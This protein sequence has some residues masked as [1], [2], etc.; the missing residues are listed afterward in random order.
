MESDN[1]LAEYLADNYGVCRRGS[2]CYHGTDERGQPNGCLK[3]GW[4]GRKC[5]YWEPLE[6]VD[7]I[8]L[9]TLATQDAGAKVT[10][11]PLVIFAAPT[12]PSPFLTMK[13]E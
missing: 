8:D 3:T 4:L 9:S 13:K 11:S 6:A 7:W 10:A 1:E 12:M 2:D 5:L